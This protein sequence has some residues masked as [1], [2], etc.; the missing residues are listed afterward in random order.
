[1]SPFRNNPVQWDG[2]DENGR[3]KNR[4]GYK[5]D[6]VGQRVVKK[7]EHMPKCYLADTQQEADAIYNKFKKYLND[8]ATSYAISTGLSKADLFGEGLIGLGRAYR[9][10]DP[11]RSDVF[12]SYAKFRIR[13][14]IVEFMREHASSISVPSYIRKAHANLKEIKN[15]CGAAGVKAGIVIHNQ[16]L[17]DELDTEGAVRCAE[18]IGIL[19]N[20]ANR[21]KISY[22]D[23][24]KRVELVPEN[25]EYNGQ[26]SPEEYQRDIEILEAAVVVE[27]LKEHM[28]EVE[29]AI[30]NGI[31]MDKS[32][33]QIGTELDR[34]KGWVS[35]KF[36][37][38]KERIFEM[39]QEGK[40]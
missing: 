24:I 11:S 4:G 34:T 19:I 12:V 38:L 6:I 15:I 10:W 31:M 18:L 22:A 30:C 33:E 20:S 40:L 29:L 35:G 37:A 7:A 8:I 3:Y 26:E 39:M 36:K 17:P 9:D 25:T 28:D 14:A 13:D 23:L 1:M 21:A 2:D 5:Y 27:K 16:E 32:F